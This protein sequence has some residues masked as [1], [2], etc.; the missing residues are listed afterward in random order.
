MHFR[1][2]AKN[3]LLANPPPSLNYGTR[4]QSYQGTE[5]LYKIFAGDTKLIRSLLEANGFSHT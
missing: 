4:Q 5:L 3:Q 1:A 2:I